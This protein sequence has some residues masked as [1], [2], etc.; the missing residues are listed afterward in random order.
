MTDKPSPPP[1]SAPAPTPGKAAARPVGLDSSPLHGELLGVARLEERA[2]TLA[3]GFT[4]SRNPRRGALR[5]PRRLAHDRRVLRHAYL[6]LSGD[7]QHAEAVAPGTEWLLDNFPLVEGQMREVRH[8]LPQR[9][10]RELPKLATRELAGRARIYAMAVEILRYSD[11]RLDAHRLTRFIYAYQTVAPLTIGE[12]WAW[13]SMLK[14]ALIEHLRRL[15]EEL[16]ETRAGRLAADA[17]FDAF[18]RD[19][20][21]PLPE[22]FHIAFV[23]QLLQRMREYGAGAAALRRQL[24]ERLVACGTTVEEAVRAGHQRLAMSNLSMG[25]SITSLRLCATL[26]WNDYV[27]EVSLIEGILQRDP[28]GTYGRMVFASRDRYRHAIEELADR[29]GEAQ[30][31]VALRAIESARQAAE[32]FGADQCAAHVGYHLI[33]RGRRDLER[34]V[35]HRAPLLQR[36]R[37]LLFGQAAALYLGSIAALTGAGVA[38]ALAIAGG[39]QLSAWQALLGIAVAIIPASDLAVSLLHRLVHRL[40]RPLPLPRLDLRAGVPAA[41]RTM[42]IVPTLLT[43]R[44]G[45]QRLIDQLEVHALGNQDPHVHFALLTDF[46]DAAHQFLPGED[47]VLSAAIAG[48]AALNARYAPGKADR[49]FLFHRARRWNASEGVWMGWERKRGKI[50]EFNRLL[51]GAL[52]TGFVVQVGDPAILPSVRYCLTLD[53]DTRLPRDTARQLIGVIEHPL[54]RPQFDAAERRVVEGYGILQPRVSVTMASAAG[55]LFARTYAGHTGVDPYSTAVSDTY[56]TGKSLSNLRVASAMATAVATTH[57]AQSLRE[58]ELVMRSHSVRRLPVVDEGGRLVGMLSLNDLFRW[59]DD[60]TAGATSSD[61]IHLVR[62]VA[63]LGSS[64]HPRTVAA[65]PATV[66]AP[67]RGITQRSP[68][69]ASATVPHAAAQTTAV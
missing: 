8:N 35:E 2:R 57:A 5:L 42:V 13:P 28:H 39:W 22:S 26:D 23:A 6:T 52:D 59:T 64:R 56:T 3:A 7:A 17:H 50:E 25:N 48:I 33:G 9:Y 51:R 16:L 55:S 12:L 65:K 44:E 34:D 66:A 62:T 1:P 49:F 18:E 69:A 41:A 36:L 10:Y 40:V 14:L 20:E 43:S 60:A 68:G 45:A 37:Q 58:A 21:L 63:T 38:L 61:A 30:V 19:R 47:A 46:P 4:L 31:R 67:G 11:A 24:E 27:E 29:T 53:S 54:N 32:G 15:A